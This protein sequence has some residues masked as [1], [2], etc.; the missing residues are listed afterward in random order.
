[1]SDTFTCS[2]CKQDKPR[3]E[4]R[5]FDDWVGTCR[6]CRER[7]RNRDQMQCRRENDK[8]Q[9]VLSKRNT[10]LL[11]E[12][13]GN[14]FCQDVVVT[15]E[16]LAMAEQWFHTGFVKATA[17]H[18]RRIR[19]MEAVDN[20]SARTGRALIKRRELMARYEAAYAQQLATVRV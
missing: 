17:V 14:E 20:P 13:G 5:I 11:A 6:A 4:G 2:T 15:K 3:R 12:G 16:K 10:E 1:M 18:R 7:K 19:E 9:K 8:L